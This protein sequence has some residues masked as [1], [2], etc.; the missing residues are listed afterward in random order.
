MTARSRSVLVTGASGL[1]GGLVVKNLGHKYA[2]SA[3]NRRPVKGIPCTQADIADLDAILPAFE[4]IETVIHLANYID[5]THTWERHLSAGIVGTR[6]VFEAARLNGVKRVI[7]GSTGDTQTGYEYDSQLPFGLLAAG[8]YDQAPDQWKRLTHRDPVRPKSIYGACKVFGEALGRYYSD[9]YGLSVLCIR[10]GG[11]LPD[12]K[13]ILRRH[14]PGYLS[15]ADCIQIF[16][17]CLQAPLSLKF[18]IFNA[19]SNNRYR[20]RDTAHAREVLGWE[21]TGRAEDFEIKDEGGWHQVHSK[22]DLA[23]MLRSSGRLGRPPNKD[24]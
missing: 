24:L 12:N 11:V 3:L 21:P 6:N 20:W 23:A 10:L 4:G 2:F 13:P 22:A 15:H 1:I 17:K 7:Y 19:I 9:D 18:D 16:D 14:Y 8:K 5:D